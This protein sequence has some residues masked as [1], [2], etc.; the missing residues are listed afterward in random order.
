MVSIDHN[1]LF[2]HRDADEAHDVGVRVLLEDAALLQERALLVLR[3]RHAARLHRHL[4]PRRQQPRLVH[5]AE[6]TLN[7]T[8]DI[9]VRQSLN[10]EVALNTRSQVD[11][12][13]NKIKFSSWSKKT[14]HFYL[15][16]HPDI[17]VRPLD[18]H[19]NQ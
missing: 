15:H 11:H 1:G 5:V 14:E 8:H 18:N 13:V 4:L 12:C 16:T 9:H 6:V 10:Q 2:L 3:Q 19:R 7:A 17:H